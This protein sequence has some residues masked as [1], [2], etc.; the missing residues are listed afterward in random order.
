MESRNGSDCEHNY[1]IIV[2]WLAGALQGQTLEVLGLKTGRI[3]EVF[4]FEPAEIK[5]TSGRV[6][7]M[8]RDDREHIYHI[9]EQRNLRK[10]DLYRFAAYHFLGAKRWGTKITDVILASGDVYA[11]EKKISTSSG[12]YSPVVIDFSQKDGFRRLEEIRQAVE[13]GI[14]ENWTELVFLPLYGKKIG[15]EQSDLAEKVI[16]FETELHRT[17]KIPVNLVA[18]TLVMSNR[19]IDKERLRE[20]WEEVK[21]LDI[22]EIAREKGMEEGEARGIDKGKTI[23]ILETVR[24][25]ITDALIERFRLIPPHISERIRNTENRDVLK[26]LFRQVFRCGS[27]QEFEKIL[28]QAQ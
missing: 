11:G 23:G 14:F 15:K 22:L 9:E 3:E 4:G 17:Q 12:T 7:V 5:V 2:K 26:G 28:N 27:L 16:K 25:M 21:M 10:S 20:L 19:L 13:D 24:E 18:A 1:D 6:D 8:L